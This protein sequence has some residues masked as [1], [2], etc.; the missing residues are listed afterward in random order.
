MIVFG[1]MMGQWAILGMSCSLL[2]LIGGTYITMYQ[3]EN[4]DAMIMI[5]L[6]MIMSSLAGIGAVLLSIQEVFI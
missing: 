1:L 6:A 3:P 2:S 5:G 4:K